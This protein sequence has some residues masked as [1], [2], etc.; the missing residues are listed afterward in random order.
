MPRL[1]LWTVDSFAS[2]PFEGNPAAVVLLPSALPDTLLQGVAAEVGLSETCFLL[3]L[4]GRGG[5]RWS[6]RCTVVPVYSRAHPPH[7]PPENHISTNSGTRYLKQPLAQS[8]GPQTITR[9]LTDHP[10]IQ[11]ITQAVVK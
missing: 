9:S 10:V 3:P 2:R 7:Q 11:T 1:P 6:L 4:E 8:P 5:A